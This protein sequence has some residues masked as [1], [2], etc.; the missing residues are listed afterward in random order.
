[1]AADSVKRDKLCAA[2]KAAGIRT[3]VLPLDLDG[4]FRYSCD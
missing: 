2:S 3:L 4:S 1:L